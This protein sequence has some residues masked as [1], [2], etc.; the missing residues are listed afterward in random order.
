[1]AVALTQLSEDERLFQRSVRQ[2][3]EEQI[4]ALVRGMDEAQT[5]DAALVR[6]LFAMGLMGIAVPEAEGGAGGSFFDAILAVEA[7]SAVDPAVGGLVD[8][9]NT[10]CLNALLRWGSEEQQRTFLPKLAH[11]TVGA[12][13]LS[14]ARSG[15][16]AFALETRAVRRGDDYILNGQKLW[17]TNALEA[18]L[19]LV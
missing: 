10:L 8:G 2:F 13:A 9:Q 1:M 17:I 14:E 11:E 7:I 18:G 12:Y 16:D 4:G 3:A 5:M 19:F 6:R 15:S